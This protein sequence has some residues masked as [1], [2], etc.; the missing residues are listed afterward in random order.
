MHR[1][2]GHG[3]ARSTHALSVPAGCALTTNPADWDP[4]SGATMSVVMNGD[5]PE[6]LTVRPLMASD[7]VTELTDLLHRA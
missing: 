7:S 5:L 6:S 2:A 3:R 1:S 4:A